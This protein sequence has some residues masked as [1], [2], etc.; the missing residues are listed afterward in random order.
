[1]LLVAF[2]WECNNKFV[3][4]NS[5]GQQVYYAFESEFN[6]YL[7]KTLILKFNTLL[8]WFVDTEVCMRIFCGPQRAFTIHVVDNMNVVS[9]C[10][11]MC[12]I[13]F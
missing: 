9:I 3:I 4:K 10:G 5:L 6:F 13:H 12:H 7:F 1:M 11:L 2:N 8:K